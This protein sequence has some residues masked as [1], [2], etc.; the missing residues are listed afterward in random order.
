MRRIDI[1]LF[2]QINLLDVAGPAQAFN[3][4]QRGTNKLYKTRFVSLDGE[5]VTSCC[6]LKLV[7]DGKA[8]IRSNSTDLIIPGGVGVDA[9][10]NQPQL[11]S[12][13][14]QWCSNQNRRLISVCSGALLLA[15]AG[16]L[17]GHK[18]TTHWSRSAQ[19]QR[20]YPKVHWQ[21]DQLYT[22]SG[23]IF[24]SAG[25]STGIDLTLALIQLDHNSETALAVAR[26]LVVYSQRP[27]GQ[28][29]FSGIVDLQLKTSNSLSE[30]VDTIIQYPSRT[31]SVVTMAEFCNLT[32]RTLTRHFHRYLNT[33]PKRFVERVRVNKACE[34]LSSGVPVELAIPLCGISDQQQMQRAFKRQL[35]TSINQYTER[36]STTDS[37][38][39]LTTDQ[40][41]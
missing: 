22:R 31:W 35:G 37:V 3:S 36:F 19:V 18:A 13:L 34:L 17:N 9:I 27:G 28:S 21:I 41:T 10:M 23:N 40:T 15:N 8:S 2:D 5:A 38:C 14:N 33:S 30:L 24:T 20:E 16:V 6:G 1:L 25:V 7:A 29:Q 39:S 4:A 32:E 12:L 11:Q 26:E